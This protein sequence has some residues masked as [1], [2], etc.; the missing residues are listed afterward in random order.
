MNRRGGPPHV[1]TAAR[2]SQLMG[3]VLVAAG[4]GTLVLLLQQGP[5]LAIR[6]LLTCACAMAVEAGLSVGR[7]E[8]ATTLPRDG[9]G[10]VCAALL[11]LTLP[12]GLPW[13]S[14]PLA[15]LFAI[16][17]VKQAFGGLGQNV[18]NPA[19]AGCAFAW[20]LW[21]ASGSGMATDVPA[22]W[23]GLSPLA[24]A[25]GGLLM[26]GLRLIPWRLPLAFL[27]VLVGLETLWVGGVP[28]VHDLGSM[29]GGTTLLGAFFIVTDPVSAPAT[30]RAQWCYGGLIAAAL[31]LAR[32]GGADLDPLPFAVLLGNA[33][34][35]T[36][37][38]MNMPRPSAE[39]RP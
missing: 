12:P 37:D 11:A 31:S 21:P 32:H 25:L 1:H 14:A 3:W 6:I 39:G 13:W 35:P 18:F 20:L 9:S 27:A 36:L 38:L 16:G 23:A 8:P 26:G 19:M 30:A 5:A 4:P 28:T 7:G 22:A 29:L 34:A 24:W 33:C 15:C 10:L 17:M 2:S